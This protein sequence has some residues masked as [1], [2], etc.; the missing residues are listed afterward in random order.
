[1]GTRF[2]SS[3]QFATSMPPRRKAEAEA[4]GSAPKDQR[5]KRQRTTEAEAPSAAKAG[6]I[7]AGDN[8]TAETKLRQAFVPSLSES[9]MAASHLRQAHS[10]LL[11]AFQ[12]NSPDV[13]SKLTKLKIE[14]T[15][16]GLLLPSFPT[17]QAATAGSA[18]A[19]ALPSDADSLVLAR[20]VLE[21]GAL[22]S[23]R[24]KDV[25]SFDRYMGL[26][27]VFYDDYR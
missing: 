7:A 25:K 11:T 5:I 26:L 17:A 13:R 15:E 20:D 23:I 8:P 22:W 24:M 21:V 3:A 10:D 18:K 2:P 27:R 4:S 16:A 1:M 14:L 12:S 6:A 19:Q 9:D